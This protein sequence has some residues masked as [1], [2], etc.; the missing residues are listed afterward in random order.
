MFIIIGELEEFIGHYLIPLDPCLGLYNLG[1]G[2]SLYTPPPPRH[3]P[4]NELF[5]NKDDNIHKS[6]AL[7]R[8]DRRTLTFVECQ[9]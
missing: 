9:N 4:Y 3:H 6:E 7:K 5:I 1:E 2:G 8:H